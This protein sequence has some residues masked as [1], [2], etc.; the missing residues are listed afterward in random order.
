MIPIG[1]QEALALYEVLAAARVVVLLDGTD[2]VSLSELR[3]AISK[4]DNLKTQ[5]LPLEA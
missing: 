2:R 1:I 5:G 3:D 4:Y